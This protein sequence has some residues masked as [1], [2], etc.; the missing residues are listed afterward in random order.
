LVAGLAG[1]KRKR[2]LSQSHKEKL[3]RG[4]E[5][6]GLTRDERG[7]LV[8]SQSQN[9]AQGEALVPARGVT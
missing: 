2:S 1:G 3:A 6:A 9:R 4:R 7:R 8:H 5:K